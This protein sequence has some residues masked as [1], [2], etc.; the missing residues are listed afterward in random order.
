M[1]IIGLV[2]SIAIGI[3][4]KFIAS[5]IKLKRQD[6][7]EVLNQHQNHM[8]EYVLDYFVQNHINTSKDKVKELKKIF[9]FSL[10]VI[11]AIDKKY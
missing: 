3:S 5:R 11:K 4:E 10:R 9:E 1:L 7:V 6:R 2:S 8:R